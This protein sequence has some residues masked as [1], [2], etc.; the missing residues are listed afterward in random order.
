MAT[1][2]INL[3]ATVKQ[4]ITNLLKQNQPSLIN[5]RSNMID[6]TGNT[7]IVDGSSFSYTNSDGK[8]VIP[9][10]KITIQGVEYYG[11]TGSKEFYYWRDNLN[12]FKDYPSLIGNTSAPVKTAFVS[13]S[14]GKL[15]S[16]H[17]DISLLD[18]CKYLNIHPVVANAMSKSVGSTYSTFIF[19][20]THQ[21]YTNVN[22][23]N[24]EVTGT[25]L[26]YS[27]SGNWEIVVGD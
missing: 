9:N 13:E 14:I 3:N 15:F 12:K 25:K 16:T 21:N 19:Q 22:Y 10:I 23:A 4:N 24:L 26:L 5:L 2:D 8:L 6:I 1:Y 11:G 18:I 7:L 27:S 20:N 17:A